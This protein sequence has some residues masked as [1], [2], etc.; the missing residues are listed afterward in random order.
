MGGQSKIAHMA[1]KRAHGERDRDICQAKNR[2]VGKEKSRLLQVGWRG[3]HR[4][5][6]MQSG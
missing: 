1:H 4:H 5:K 6:R 3:W 2:A